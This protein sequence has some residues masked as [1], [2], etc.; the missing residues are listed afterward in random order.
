MLVGRHRKFPNL[1]LFTRTSWQM[2]PGVEDPSRA[3]FTI[4]IVENICRK[5]AFCHTSLWHILNIRRILFRIFLASH[6]TGD[7]SLAWVLP[8]RCINSER[9]RPSRGS[10]THCSCGGDNVDEVHVFVSAVIGTNYIL[11]NVT[12]SA[13]SIDRP[14]SKSSWR[15]KSEMQ[16]LFPLQ[17]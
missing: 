16:N 12:C 9:L 14:P 13:I 11:S 17:S 10:L 15:S 1:V 2:L 5:F 8:W 3:R 4:S 6:A 7:V